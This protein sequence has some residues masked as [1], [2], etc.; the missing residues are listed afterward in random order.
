MVIIAG[1]LATRLKSVA[2][3]TP[4]SMVPV[5]GK[6]FLEY[7]L[8]FL[9]KGGIGDIVLCTGYLGE[10]I[11]SHFGDGGR[12]GVNI[13]YSREDK[14]LGT[15]GALKNAEALL[16]DI[17]F[18]LY[19]DSYLFLDFASAMS[20]FESNS[21]LALMSVYKNY[22]QY[23]RSNT[24]VQGG[25]VKKY[26]KREKTES[27]IYIDY[28]SN[29]FRKKVLEMIPKGEPCDLED[30]LSLLVEKGQLLAYEVNERFYEIGSPHGLDEFNRYAQASL[31]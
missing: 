25:M 24:V 31:V 29:I 9:R 17:F 4:K 2:E 14:L 7:Q 6:P 22:D 20:H 12:F 8:E 28:G 1:G 16:G 23:D 30:I 10:Q 5:L 11:E 27:M 3:N 18:T 19:G 15:A 13:M 21:K 26:S